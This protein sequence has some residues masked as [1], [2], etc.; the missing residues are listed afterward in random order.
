ALTGDVEGAGVAWGP[1]I[2]AT[3]IAFAVGLTVIA[4]L[5]RYLDRGSFT[6]FVVYRVL[7]GLTVLALVAAGVLDP[8]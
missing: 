1:T 2:L 6:P 8:V 4:W 3:V 7:L 5:L